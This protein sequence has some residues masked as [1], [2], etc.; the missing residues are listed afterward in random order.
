MRSAS[1]RMIA[2][3]AR[4]WPASVSNCSSLS[5]DRSSDALRL[6]EIV[7]TAMRTG[8][9]GRAGSIGIAEAACPG[10]ADAILA[11]RKSGPFALCEGGTADRGLALLRLVHPVVAQDRAD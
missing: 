4:M 3:A 6:S 11:V 8:L 5:P 2:R 9:K 7:R 10:Q 1:S